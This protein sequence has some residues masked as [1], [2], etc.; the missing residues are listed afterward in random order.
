MKVIASELST[1]SLVNDYVSDLHRLLEAAADAE[2]QA[3]EEVCDLE[4]VT[5]AQASAFRSAIDRLNTARE[6]KEAI[7]AQ[8][9]AIDN[10]RRPSTCS[11][12]DV[13]P[14]RA[15]GSPSA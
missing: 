6:W 13:S 9:T 14:V 12:R 5:A 3:E 7:A 4:P 8:L 10:R 2:R 1:P 15:D 11:S